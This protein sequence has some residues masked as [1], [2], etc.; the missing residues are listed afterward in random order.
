MATC[1]GSSA[2]ER[3]ASFFR[4]R[5]CDSFGVFTVFFACAN[6][7]SNGVFHIYQRLLVTGGTI[8]MN[9]PQHGTLNRERGFNVAVV[10]VV[11]FLVY[12]TPFCPYPVSVEF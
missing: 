11:V 12:G 6:G 4:R 2:L 7:S 5:I 1:L 8:R 10:I 9:W 3:H